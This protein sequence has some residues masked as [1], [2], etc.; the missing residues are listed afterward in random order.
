MSALQFVGKGSMGRTRNIIARFRTIFSSCLYIGG[1]HKKLFIAHLTNQ[2]NLF[3]LIFLTAFFTAKLACKRWAVGKG[4]ATIYTLL[5]L[6][7]ISQNGKTVTRTVNSFGFVRLKWLIAYRTNLCGGIFR[8][9]IQIC[10]LYRAVLLG[11]TA[12]CGKYFSAFETRSSYMVGIFIAHSRTIQ[13]RCF[14][15]WT[16]IIRRSAQ[17]T[18]SIGFSGFCFTHAPIISRCGKGVK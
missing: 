6:A 4:I 2:F 14:L 1:G 18:G 8:F 17:H 10:A 5:R 11:V 16:S 3:V 7:L 13:V 12:F 15:V 9:Q